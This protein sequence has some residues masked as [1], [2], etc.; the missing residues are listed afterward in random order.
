[1][2]R[3]A[4]VTLS[5]KDMLSGGLKSA[6]GSVLSFGSEV[7]S[8][9]GN[10]RAGTSLV[11]GE[12]ARLPGVFAGV[13]SSVTS[14]LRAMGGA[15]AGLGSQVASALMHPVATA[16]SLGAAL[17]GAA[18]SGL[19][20][21]RAGVSGAV[22]GVKAK[23]D[24]LALSVAGRVEALGARVQAGGEAFHAFS[25]RVVSALSSPQS[26]MQALASGA[27]NLGSALRS[28]IT[29]G[30]DA[31]GQALSRLASMA[32]SAVEAV[33]SGAS[34]IGSRLSGM[35]SS[36]LGAAG[37]ASAGLLTVGAGFVALGDKAA[38]ADSLQKSFM[39][40]MAK[41]GQDGVAVLDKLRASSLGMVT[42]QELMAKTTM[43]TMLIGEDVMSQFGGS[44]EVM[45]KLL[46][47]AQASARA[48][49]QDVN[50]LFDSVV[51]GVARASPAILDNLGLSIKL[52]SAY[53][54]FAASVGK[55]PDALTPAE[56]KQAI[57]NQVLKQ[58]QGFIEDYG[59]SS[60]GVR[61]K[62]Q[63]FAAAIENTAVKIGSTFLPVMGKLYDIGLLVVSG[64]D[65]IIPALTLLFNAI[66]QIPTPIFGAIAGFVALAG[67]AR[68]LTMVAGPLTSLIPGLGS[69]IAMLGPSLLTLAAPVGI[70]IGLL[71]AFQT[72][73]FGVRDAVTGALGPVIDLFSRLGSA[74]Q[75]GFAAFQQAQ[76]LDFS[77]FDSLSIG[78]QTVAYTL[79][80]TPLYPLFQSLANASL[81]LKPAFDQVAAVLQGGLAAGLT[82]LSPLLA[83]FTTFLQTAGLALSQLFSGDLLGGLQTLIGGFL[84]FNLTATMALSNLILTVVTKGI[85]FA[86][87]IAQWVFGALPVWI[88]SLG[89]L[90]MSFL[91]WVTGSLIP[92]LLAFGAQAA[93]TLVSWIQ[94]AIPLVVGGLASLGATIFNGIVT[95]VP[96]IVSTVLGWASAL[97]SW[98][99]SATSL[100]MANWPMI[101]STIIGFITG[102]IAWIQST[103]LGW[104]TALASWIPGA[105][106]RL[107]SGVGSILGSVVS[108]LVSA[109]PTLIGAVFRWAIAIASF[110]LHAIPEVLAALARFIGSVVSWIITDGLP[111]LVNAA[112]NLASGL[113]RGFLN[114]LTGG[115]GGQI[116][117]AAATIPT[118]VQRGVMQPGPWAAAGTGASQGVMSIWDRIKSSIAAGAGPTTAAA[119]GAAG[120]VAAAMNPAAAAGGG[121]GAGA[122]KAAGG[123]G[124]GGGG[125]GAAQDPAQA[126]MQAI[127]GTTQALNSLIDFA[128]K[129]FKFRGFPPPAI[130]DNLFKGLKDIIQRAISLSKGMKPEAVELANS[131]GQMAS[132]WIQALT[133]LVDLADKMARFRPPSGEAEAQLM[134]MARWLL[135]AAAALTKLFTGGKGLEE[136]LAKAAVSTKVAEALKAWAELFKTMAEAT[137]ALAKAR[138]DV[139]LSPVMAFVTRLT[140][141]VLTLT[142][143][144]QTQLGDT[145]GMALANAQAV[146][147]ML[148]P[149]VDLIKAIAETTGALARARW[150]TDLGAPERFI[151]GLA[152]MVLR[153]TALL[154]GRLGYAILVA[155][156]DSRNIAETLKAWIEPLS[157]VKE[158]TASIARMRPVEMGGAEGFLL[159]ILDMSMRFTGL[160]RSRLGPML[161]VSLEDSKAIA[162]TLGAWLAP[163]EKVGAV[164]QSIDVVRGLAQR[165]TDDSFGAL[166]GFLFGLTAVLARFV[167]AAQTVLGPQLLVALEDSREIAGAL[168][169]WLDPL[170]KIGSV[171]DAIDKVR[172]YAKVR[173]DS[174]FSAVGEFVLGIAA[175]MG[176]IV[177]R[178]QGVLGPAILVALETSSEVAKA[179][180][181]WLDMLSKAGAAADSVDKVT[182]YAQ[183]RMDVGL[184]SVFNFLAE[185]GQRGYNILLA[186]QRFPSPAEAL[187]VSQIVAQTFGAWI[188]MLSKVG[189][190]VDSI[191]KIGRLQGD[192][193]D[194]VQAFLLGIA[195]R[196]A[197]GVKAVASW[198]DPAAL[199]GVSQTVAQT[200][201]TWLDML[202]KIGSAVTAMTGLD[203]V[204]PGV[205]AGTA[206]WLLA[207][208]ATFAPLVLDLNRRAD[209]K[210]IQ[211]VSQTIGQTI[212]AW[213][214]VLTKAASMVEKLAMIEPVQPSQWD[215]IA[216]AVQ[217]SITRALSLSADIR[218]MVDVAREALIAGVGEYTKLAGDAIGLFD[219]AAGLGARMAAAVLPTPETY[220]VVSGI[221]EQV[222]A[223]VRSLAEG[224]M[225]RLRSQAIRLGQQVAEYVKVGSD[226]ISLFDKAAGLGAKLRDAARPAPGDYLLVGDIIGSVVAAVV[227]LASQI[228]PRLASEQRR[229]GEG[230]TIYTKLAGDAVGLFDKA[231]GLGAKLRAAV[232]PT[233]DQYILV[234]GVIAAV[235]RQV[236]S[237]A[238]DI[239]PRA[240]TE[241]QAMVTQFDLFNKIAS[242]AIDLVLKAAGIGEA[243]QGAVQASALRL[244]YVRDGVLMVVAA[245]GEMAAGWVAAQARVSQSVEDIK[246]FSG[247]AT[248]ALAVVKPA[249]DALQA[250]ATPDLLPASRRALTMVG[251]AIVQIVGLIE[252]VSAGWRTATGEL[253][254]ARTDGIEGFAKVASAALG[255]V[256]DV[257]DVLSKLTTE[258]GKLGGLTGAARAQIR[259]G[260]VSLVGLMTELSSGYNAGEVEGRMAMDA[261]ASFS[262]SVGEIVKPVSDVVKVLGDVWS[263]AFA[264]DKNNADKIVP[265]ARDFGVR[266]MTG[267]RLGIEALVTTME[268]TYSDLGPV[269]LKRA[270]AAS[271]VVGPVASA[272]GAMIEPLQ[273]LLDN[274][275]VDAKRRSSSV[276][277]NAAQTRIKQLAINV[278]KGVRTMAETLIKALSSINVPDGLENG[279]NRLI[280]VV[281]GIMAAIQQAMALPPIDFGKIDDLVRAANIL[282][283]IQMPALAG[284]GAGGFGGPLVTLPSGPVVSPPSGPVTLPGMGG[285]GAG[286][287]SEPPII[288]GPVT[289]EL[290]N[291]VI[292]GDVSA[293]GGVKFSGTQQVDVIVSGQVIQ[294]TARTGE[295]DDGVNRKARTAPPA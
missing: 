180:Q 79:Q 215:I 211:Q 23:F 227:V 59:I 70:V 36:A 220:S 63:Q 179:F 86:A 4:T 247:A 170:S 11:A 117:Q 31:A 265:V 231:A 47:V 185:L 182:A 28:G 89:Q 1:M 234:S 252:D 236:A 6:A 27:Q 235:V 131:V 203:P 224:A 119:K 121:G 68:A 164:A 129:A 221:I 271:R 12:A 24:D 50:F 208:A 54:E 56:Q 277:A 92:M 213:V 268:Q 97:V 15:F 217:E 242:P 172:G 72:N 98:I 17:S 151:L 233:L 245:V 156:E 183:Q 52:E 214:D 58:G 285:G 25:A 69:V 272:I 51:R 71:L 91:S 287:P 248:A 142:Q 253:D 232:A 20:S 240:Q 46:N 134:A 267:I 218:A 239:I 40:S 2:G 148:K 93:A 144:L 100:I 225:P 133:G 189:A 147:D 141:F 251:R 109:V 116:Q 138:F 112:K 206:D 130:M 262:K 226:A 19:A 244:G 48:T 158:V 274:P 222:L 41:S 223:A 212:G 266:T 14:D 55:L 152:D 29:G 257:V 261:V 18:S 64:I 255:P 207:I 139:D 196:F 150:P 168:G 228:M 176:Q 65:K 120:Q 113:V 194:R 38:R 290:H 259:A 105:I 137:V 175:S 210:M 96:M 21:L 263:F 67:G 37:T 291:A 44:G 136:A 250:L 199:Q 294:R 157:K 145:L 102:G 269:L 80:S 190:A 85:E 195:V 77:F 30:A 254:R 83:S 193:L 118:A 3:E 159:S 74:V 201:G 197:A 177:G 288:Q 107:A 7:K 5:F 9:M 187:S 205:V 33:S 283:G 163:L 282:G 169:A 275:F 192:E 178:A 103:V 161:L 53:G 57:L 284:A 127:Q 8:G 188:E 243:L 209:P 13:A 39:M 191:R 276:M 126:A 90:G 88:A 289:L 273:K 173:T 75:S 32:R 200:F 84:N 260:I 111:M 153:I 293:Q 66:G 94:T 249:V 238:G 202:G 204:D 115:G 135:L 149:W 246:S 155:L 279:V 81:L 16:Q 264:P 125:G 167:S 270:E 60:G 241:A 162:D 146:A 95:V 165:R 128:E 256:K 87:A 143:A 43:G 198:P 230:I 295:F 174:S 281:S 154:R 258:Q 78:L 76:G 140:R 45:S 171:A 122:G 166:E 132:G 26:A 184:G 73:L 82:M 35:A 280:G 160:V 61:T 229:F 237:L 123:G 124:G 108:F 101:Q 286:R 181:P 10:V 22:D 104:A 99:G 62:Q 278:E 49:G 114:A 292:T 106:G 42:D 219:K 34:S 216:S 186:V 110:A